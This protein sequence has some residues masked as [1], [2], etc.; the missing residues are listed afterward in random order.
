MSIP[1][2]ARACFSNARWEVQVRLALDVIWTAQTSFIKAGF[3]FSL[4]PLCQLEWLKGFRQKDNKVPLPFF[5][6]SYNASLSI[7]GLRL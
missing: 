7:R 6:P 2:K 3:F 5:I 4:D 1:H